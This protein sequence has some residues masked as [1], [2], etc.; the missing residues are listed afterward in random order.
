MQNTGGNDTRVPGRTAGGRPTRKFSPFGCLAKVFGVVLVLGLIGYYVLFH[1]SM[2]L[3]WF[4]VDN[5]TINGKP[6]EVEG[7]SGSLSRGFAVERAVVQGEAGESTIE[8]LRFRYS[9]LLDS[10]QNRQLVIEEVSVVRADFVV[11]NDFFKRSSGKDESGN[12]GD[13]DSGKSSSS[14]DSGS[15]GG[16]LRLFELRELNLAETRIRTGDGEFEFI[17]PLIRLAGLKIED[18][19]FDLAELE[20]VSD[21]LNL[22]LLD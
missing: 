20:V 5:M 2:P 9:G 13:G 7:V 12:R 6:V 17:I 18:D 10:I 3:K 1:T 11:G 19:D 14:G 8:G 21:F 15:S 4:V 22:E 16:G